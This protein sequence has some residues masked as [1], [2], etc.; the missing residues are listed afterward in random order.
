VLRSDEAVTTL[1]AVWG[2]GRG[3]RRRPPLSLQEALV[4]TM[5]LEHSLR[6]LAVRLEPADLNHTVAN[7]LAA[8]VGVVAKWEDGT[9]LLMSE[10]GVYLRE[11]YLAYRGSSLGPGARAVLLGFFRRLTT[12]GYR[13]AAFIAPVTDYNRRWEI[14][15][16][17]DPASIV[18]V[19]N[20]VDPEVFGELL[21]EPAEPVL[22]WVGRIDPLKD[23]ETLLHAFAL[24]RG[25][26]PGARLRMFGPV[27]KGN[28]GYA[29]RCAAL[30]D[31]LGITSTATFEGPVASSR[32]AFAAGQ[33]VLLSSIS[34]G[35]PYTV[36]EAMMCRRPTVSTDVGGVAECVA[37]AG[38]VVPPRDPAA[39]AAACVELLQDA[40]FRSMLSSSARDRALELFTLDRCT[41]TYRMLYEAT[42]ATRTWSVPTRSRHAHATGG[43]GVP[44]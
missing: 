42:A 1:A 22:T 43:V 29:A 32:D 3:A 33:V 38:V 15:A 8:L 26:V 5:L 24:V 13:E 35:L 12:L 4:A 28:E 41:G 44:A 9:P 27:P 10:H 18:T 40:A 6:P 21:T 7:G 37:D 11:R 16:G 34:E 31:E 19:H 20:G 36:I 30:A 25:A 2:R 14:R 17:A 23:V 39:F